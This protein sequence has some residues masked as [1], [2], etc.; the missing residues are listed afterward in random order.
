MESPPSRD[1]AP[2]QDI[3]DRYRSKID[4]LLAKYPGLSAVRVTQEI[5]T[6]ENGE[7][8]YCGSV[9]PVR[10]YLHQVCP[11]RA[12]VYQEVMNIFRKIPSFLNPCWATG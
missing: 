7:D 3:L 5:S 1:A 10:R 11:P 12:R 6:G 4:A 2:R 8:G 9:Y